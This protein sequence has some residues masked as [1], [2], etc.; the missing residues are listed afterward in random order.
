MDDESRQ[1]L[2]N[3]RAEKYAPAPT[4]GSLLAGVCGAVVALLGDVGVSAF[5]GWRLRDHLLLSAGVTVIGFL[6]VFVGYKR[7]GRLSRAAR[8]SER[9]QVDV[10]QDQ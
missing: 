9:A 8:K 1:A 6:I 4:G 10:E 7:L 2:A 3:D 5:Y